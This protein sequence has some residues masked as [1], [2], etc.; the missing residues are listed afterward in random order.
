MRQFTIPLLTGLFCLGLVGH[1]YGDAPA[2]AKECENC[3]GPGGVSKHKDIPTIAGMSAFYLDGQVMAYQKG[4]RPCPSTKYPD[5][6][7]KPAT[8]M[9]KNAK[10]LSAADAT[11][12]DKYF[13]SQKFMPAKQPFDAAAAARGKQ[14]HAAECEKCHTEG[15]SVADDDAGI[16]AGQWIAY[17]QETFK[18][19]KSGKRIMEKKMKPAIDK[20]TPEKINDLVQYYASE[21]K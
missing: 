7:S 12:V 3:H 21:G 20:L 13:A 17:L 4:Q 5:D 2:A 18:E 11:A 15:G 16:L 1:A 6:P 10:K 9:C 8:D 19:Y 14:I